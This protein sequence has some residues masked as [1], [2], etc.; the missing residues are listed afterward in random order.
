MKSK[1]FLKG[2][3]VN[4]FGL[5]AIFLISSPIYGQNYSY[6]YTM[7]NP[8]VDVWSSGDFYNNFLFT[9]F[10]QDYSYS[11]IF[12]VNYATGTDYYADLL[13][14]Q[15]STYTAA[16]LPG[17]GFSIEYAYDNSTLGY[18]NSYAGSITTPWFHY[19]SA[20]TASSGFGIVPT[21]AGYMPLMSSAYTSTSNAYGTPT[22]WSLSGNR[23]YEGQMALVANAPYSAQMDRYLGDNVMYTA[24]GMPFYGTAS[25]FNP[26]STSN[27]FFPARSTSY[28]AVDL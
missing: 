27:W 4:I 16:N 9:S 8:L 3:I 15:G 13:S 20:V 26:Y 22:I 18:E 17:S 23:A 7:T 1:R 12:G 6:D 2:L 19:D 5:I 11:D 14:S 28:T 10:D 25:Y 24:Q 21:M